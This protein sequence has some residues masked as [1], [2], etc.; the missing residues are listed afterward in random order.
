MV[1]SRRHRRQFIRK[2]YLTKGRAQPSA[3]VRKM[4]ALASHTDELTAPSRL[5]GVAASALRLA[6]ANKV[7][8]TLRSVRTI[9]KPSA[10]QK[11]QRLLSAATASNTDKRRTSIWHAR[12]TRLMR[13]AERGLPAWSPQYQTRRRRWASPRQDGVL[14]R[15][16]WPSVRVRR[17]R[18]KLNRALLRRHLPQRRY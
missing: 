15:R 13:Q 14:L 1:R 11:S 12:S 10:S 16:P 9:A 6:F 4:A 17:E 2:R 5:S 8:P 3:Y 18:H 7:R